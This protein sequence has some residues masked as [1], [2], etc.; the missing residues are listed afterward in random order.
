MFDC[1]NERPNGH[2]HSSSNSKENQ[3]VIWLCCPANYAASAVMQKFC[4]EK[5][6]P[7]AAEFF[8]LAEASENSPQFQLRVCV[9]KNK[10]SP[11]GATDSENDSARRVVG[12][13]IKLDL[14]F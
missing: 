6:T 9:H 2:C 1:F 14:A 11:G 12:S 8:S 3:G 13:L 7:A 4:R 5:I 10:S